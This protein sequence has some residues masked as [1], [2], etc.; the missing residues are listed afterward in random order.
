MIKRAIF[1]EN[2][3]QLLESMKNYKKIKYDDVKCETFG[4]KEY[5]LKLTLSEAR[6]KFAIKTQQIRTVRMNQMNNAEYAR[7]CW[8]CIHCDLAGQLSADS[9]AH[10]TY[11]PSYQHLREGK[12]LQDD[13][14]LV[15]YFQAV[16]QLRDALQNG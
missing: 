12:N 1:D 3:T 8:R 15:A 2:Q 10:V 13:K 14:D 4:L 7:L 16:L 6:T 11:C 9:M 5:F